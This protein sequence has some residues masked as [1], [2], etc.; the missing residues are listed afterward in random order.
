MVN[1]TF[2]DA[3]ST[4]DVLASCWGPVGQKG[5]LQELRAR[6]GK[7]RKV[8]NGIYVIHDRVADGFSYSVVNNDL[9]YYPD[10][11]FEEFKAGFGLGGAIPTP[12]AIATINANAIYISGCDTHKY[13]GITIAE[14]LKQHQR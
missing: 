10:F 8:P 1:F 7:W 12:V 14:V 6:F 11:S 2:T 4:P 3:N 5:V 13:L 9:A